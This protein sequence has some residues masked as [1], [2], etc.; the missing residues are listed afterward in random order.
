MISSALGSGLTSELMPESI[1]V[2]DNSE[3]PDEFSKLAEIVAGNSRLK[4]IAVKNEGYF[5]ALNKGLSEVRDKAA[6]IVVVCNNDILFDSTFFR[7]LRQ[8]EYP[9]GALVVAPSVLTI[10]GR[11][12]NP[13]HIRRIGFF[14]R[15]AFDIYFT[16]YYLACVLTY[17]SRTMRSLV[18]ARFSR[19]K[20]R[21]LRDEIAREIEQGVG[22]IYILRPQFFEKFDSLYYEWFL[23]GEEACL[24]WQLRTVN[25]RIWFDPALKVVHA[26]SQTL[27]RLPARK[28]YGFARAS[29]WGYR[30][31][32]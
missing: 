5:S 8:A 6:S 28:T 18:E 32:L 9:T 22:A 21:N 13:H 31:L 30:P 29:Y 26:E 23:Y 25:S 1:V 15:L 17:I 16:H 20:N 4:L 2:I 7:M 24:A 3:D 27:G 11:P 19:I 12:Q 14:R 10:A